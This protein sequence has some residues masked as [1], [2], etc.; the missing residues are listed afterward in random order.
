MERVI[1]LKIELVAM[2]VIYVFQ[3]ILV[4]TCFVEVYMFLYKTNQKLFSKMVSTE[5]R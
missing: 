2:I 4:N 5:L 3:Y 1:K